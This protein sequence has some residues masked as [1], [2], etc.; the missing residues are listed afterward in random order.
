MISRR[1]F[2]E[3]NVTYFKPAGIPLAGLGEVIL[4][5]E[6]LEALRLKD[7]DG[8][9]Q[10]KAAEKMGISQPTFFRVLS[11]ARKKVADGV[12]NGKAIRIEG[13][14]YFFSGILPFSLSVPEDGNERK[15]KNGRPGH[16]AR[17]RLLL[18]GVRG[19]GSAQDQHSMHRNEVPEVRLANGKEIKT[20]K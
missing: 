4:S 9:S 20:L 1:V 2:F 6:E 17:R 14:N 11:T 10:S 8:L 18:P 3:P 15:R 19:N 16:G 7:V 5:V 13:G 12:V